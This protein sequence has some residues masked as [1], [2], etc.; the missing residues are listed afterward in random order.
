M[1][2]IKKQTVRM[3]ASDV[4]CAHAL[5]GRPPP[6]AR[7][8]PLRERGTAPVTGEFSGSG[9]WF[10]EPVPEEMLLIVRRYRQV[11]RSVQ[12]LECLDIVVRI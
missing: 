3:N 9:R 4:E 2:I 6:L 10:S 7:I 8:L 12:F 1:A 11:L 5:Y